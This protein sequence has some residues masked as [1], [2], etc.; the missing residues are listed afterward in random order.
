M[1]KVEEVKRILAGHKRELRQRFKVK[2]IGVFGSLVRGEERKASDVDVLVEFVEPVGFF[3][4]IALEDYL[5]G[6]LGVRVDLV[7]K[8]ALKPRIGERVLKEVAYV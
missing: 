5:S 6:L 4:F 1:E 3:E 8:K 7:S 2:S